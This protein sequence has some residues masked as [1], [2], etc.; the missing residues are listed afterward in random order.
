MRR[1]FQTL[2]VVHQLLV[3][4]VL[5]VQSATESWL[6][7]EAQGFADAEGSLFGEA[8]GDPRFALTRWLWWVL[9]SGSLLASVGAL[10][11]RPWARTLFV[12][13]A[14][15]F[16]LCAPLYE[17]YLDTGWTVM[18]GG[19]AGLC[20]GVIIALMYFSPARRL[21][22]RGGGAEAAV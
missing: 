10:F 12:L 7:P 9:M 16:V 19:L 17:F 5:V 4:A 8:D 22:A 21:F 3:F 18:L 14:V 13:T 6:P 1:N 2:V 20:E 11:F 15:G